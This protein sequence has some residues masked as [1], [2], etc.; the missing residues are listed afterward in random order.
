[1]LWMIGAQVLTDGKILNM[2][3]EKTR[4]IFIVLDWQHEIMDFHS[5]THIEMQVCVCAQA[6]VH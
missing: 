1:M 5:D 3:S 4:M 6:L 2:E